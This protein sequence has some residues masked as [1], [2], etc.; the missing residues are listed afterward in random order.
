MVISGL[1]IFPACN[2]PLSGFFGTEEAE[3]PE[4]ESS[5]FWETLDAVVM[6]HRMSW[7]VFRLYSR[8]EL[9]LGGDDILAGCSSFGSCALR[10]MQFYVS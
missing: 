9:R 4:V 5:C 10:V 1:S 3:G 7:A 2:L 8:Y 6:I